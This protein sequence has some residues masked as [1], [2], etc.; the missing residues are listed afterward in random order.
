MSR[1]SNTVVYIFL[2]NNTGYAIHAYIH[3]I[4][5]YTHGVKALEMGWHI[6][7]LYTCYPFMD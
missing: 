7:G 6:L 5:I 4:Y 2:I 1:Y 3:I